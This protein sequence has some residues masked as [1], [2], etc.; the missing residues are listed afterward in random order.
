MQF[1]SWKIFL[2][3]LLFLLAATNILKKPQ[4]K[5]HLAT[6]VVW[7]HLSYT[8]SCEMFVKCEQPH[9]MSSKL[10]LMS[11]QAVSSRCKGRISTPSGRPS[12]RRCSQARRWRHHQARSC[13]FLLIFLFQSSKFLFSAGPS[14]SMSIFRLSRWSI[15]VVQGLIARGRWFWQAACAPDNFWVFWQITSKI[16][17]FFH[18]KI[19]LF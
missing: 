12:R 11:W 18:G 6:L 16:L 19:I 7:Q 3:G 14:K 8:N 1:L 17:N 5:S 15:P 2:S 13:W 4:N 10:W 9:F